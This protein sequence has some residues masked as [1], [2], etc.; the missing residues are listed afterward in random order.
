VSHYDHLIGNRVP[1]LPEKPLLEQVECVIIGCAMLDETSVSL[2]LEQV[3]PHDMQSPIG[4]LLWPIVVDLYQRKLPI[5]LLHIGRIGM[6][7]KDRWKAA[8]GMPRLAQLPTTIP[9]AVF[10]TKYAPMHAELRAEQRLSDAVA[11]ASAT[12]DPQE[13][14]LLLRDATRAF[15][16]TA[17]RKVTG[18]WIGTVCGEIKQR[19]VDVRRGLVV[20]RGVHTPWANLNE[21]IGGALPAGDY[22]VLAGLAK[23]G[24]SAG[25]E[26]IVQ[27]TAQTQGGVLVIS[28]EMLGSMHTLRM[29]QRAG[30]H[31]RTV[32]KL[33]NDDPIDNVEA[34]HVA[35]FMRHV[36]EL[37]IRF[38]EMLDEPRVDLV[39]GRLRAE[40]KRW[41]SSIPCKLIVIDH[42]TDPLARQVATSRGPGDSRD[43]AAHRDV[44][45]GD[46]VAGAALG[47]AL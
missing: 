30:L 15:E 11:V 21:A 22:T 43:G 28:Q 18:K 8:G 33:R 47:P 2:A 38:A 17:E 20:K 7:E 46:A 4:S 9:N 5:D 24:K 31:W 34:E 36:E 44:R 3:G 42:L 41:Q 16:A 1:G 25:G 6:R 12:Q 26:Q 23:H 32:S 37:P 13:R 45:E 14:A 35:R 27:H 29:L 10:I 39:I 40:L 19:I